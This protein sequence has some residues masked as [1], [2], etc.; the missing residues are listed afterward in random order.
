MSG[1]SKWATIKRQKGVADSKRSQVFTKLAK[2][3]TVAARGGPDQ[4]MNPRLR[5]AIDKARSLSM[6][7]DNIERAILKGSGGE[8]GAQI[9]EIRYEAYGPGGVALLIDVVTDNR[10]RAASEIRHLVE[11]VGGR[12]AEIGSVGWMF[13]T[14]G[15]IHFPTPT[16]KDE[17][18]LE[19][20]EAGAD[21]IE[22]HEG[23]LSV[24]SEPS[25]FESVKKI[26]AAH[27]LEPSYLAIEPLAKTTTTPPDEHAAA[28]LNELREALDA[29]DDVSN[30]YD[31]EA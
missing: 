18:E 29:N 3:I 11:H 20:I 28:K 30:I 26:L 17:L 14:K 12:M 19:L 16:N 1:H 5:M 31:N 27:K 21:D 13:N 9:E 4:D 24:T 15:V 22:E 2:A 7:K 10:N 8:D 23:E 25:A 6:P